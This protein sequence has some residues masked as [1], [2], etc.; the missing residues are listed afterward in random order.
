MTKMTFDI[1]EHFKKVEVL[2]KGK[3]ELID[4]MVSHPV[5]KVV[6]SARVSFNKTATD[7]TDKDVRL[8]KYLIDHEH[9]STLRHSYFSFRVKAPLAVFRQWWK[10]QVGSQWIENENVGSIEIPDTSWNE[11]CLSPDTL[12]FYEDNNDSRRILNKISLEKLNTWWKNGKANKVKALRIRSVDEET[13][14]IIHGTIKDVIERGMQ[15]VYEITL[16]SGR[17]IKCT[18]THRILTRQGWKTMGESISPTKTKNVLTF[19]EDEWATNG[20]PVVGNGEY[21]NKE[22]LKNHLDSGLTYEAIA[23]IS[24]C[25]AHTIRKW[26]RKV[27][28]FG[29]SFKFNEKHEPWNKGRKYKNPN[30]ILTQEHKETI[31]NARSGSKSNFWKGG[32]TTERRK[33]TTWT[34]LNAPEIHKQ[35]NYTCQKCFKAGDRLM[36][37]HLI[38]VTM[39][40]TQAYNTNNL[41]TVCR[42]CH[43]EIHKNRQ[44]EIEF[45]TRFSN[46]K[47]DDLIRQYV[48]SPVNRKRGKT[49]LQVAYDKVVNVTHI[50]QIN[51]LDL[52]ME[53][54]N[55]NFVANGIV[56]HN[57]GRY[58]E[59]EPEFYIPNEIR[60]QS[61]NNKQGSSGKLETLAS[62]VDP[63]DFFKNVCDF[64]YESYKRIVEA[65]GAKEQARMLLPQNIY[66]ECI[67]TCSLQTILFFLHQ[68][69]K[70]DAQWE[71]REYA[72]AVKKLID[73]MLHEIL[74]EEEA[75]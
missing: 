40:V 25:S 6:N 68:R 34:T 69:L 51:C 58:I 27:G 62:G 73:P 26:V 60:I 13:G 47:N 43:S 19:K 28:L 64:Q 44:T 72:K 14:Q 66:S 35:N 38:P 1:K 49:N 7:L 61:K 52:E 15:D 23:N 9:L 5:L 63:V 29:N 70:E 42:P 17:K 59:F 3:V 54:K 45:L 8:V 37:H 48:T 39:D 4:G 56:V 22:W 41:T 2:D 16:A 24:G 20:I 21:R 75:K 53:G 12:V 33:I 18:K 46:V 11:A 36:A 55:K 71:I 32:T 10:Y 67:W 31:R 65:G 50:G 57:S 30:R 74:T